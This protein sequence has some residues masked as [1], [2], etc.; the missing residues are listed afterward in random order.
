MTLCRF[1]F[2]FGEGEGNLGRGNLTDRE[3]KGS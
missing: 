1:V 3:K 2:L